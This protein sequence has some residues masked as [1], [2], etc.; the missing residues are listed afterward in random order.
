DDPTA[1]LIMEVIK[2]DSLHKL[3]RQIKQEAERS[4]LT[5]AKLISPVIEDSFSTGYNWCV[6][7]IKASNYAPLAN[8]LEI[9]KAIM[10][11]RQKDIVQAVDTL[12]MFEK[13]ETKVASTAATNLAFINYLVGR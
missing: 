10:F 13:K 2:N 4:I 3:E 1:N 12:R 9:N 6:E 11:L 7:T 8:D 5:A